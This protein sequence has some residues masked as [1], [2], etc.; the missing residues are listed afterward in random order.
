MVDELVVRVLAL[1]WVGAVVRP[2]PV[3]VRDEKVLRWDVKARARAPSVVLGGV[4]AH[5]HICRVAH[6]RCVAPFHAHARTDTH[7]RTHTYM[8]T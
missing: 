8:H 1:R 2:E 3:V 5:Q 6:P 7:A 4:C